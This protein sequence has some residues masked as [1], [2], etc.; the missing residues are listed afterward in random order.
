MKQQAL[1][2][3]IDNYRKCKKSHLE[4]ELD[5]YRDKSNLNDAL[6]AAGLF[7]QD[8][9]V[10]HNHQYRIR[11]ISKEAFSKNLSAIKIDNTK[12]FTD[13]YGMVKACKVQG[14]GPVTIYDTAL[15]LSAFRGFFPNAI[16]LHAG[17]AIGYKNLTGN[18]PTS[19]I[20]PYTQDFKTMFNGLLAYETV[21]FLCLYKDELKD[22]TLSVDSQCNPNSSRRNI[23]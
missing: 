15:R 2:R 6:M 21:N 14:I 10:I 4:K 19:L 3:L 8:T 18:I 22:P 11:R 1:N 9:N 20:I 13:I 7:W 17:V 16:Y 23:C 12:S 5:Y